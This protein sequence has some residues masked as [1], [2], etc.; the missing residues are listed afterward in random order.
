MSSPLEPDD[1]PP[2]QCYDSKG[3]LGKLENRVS[4]GAGTCVVQGGHEHVRGW[5]TNKQLC[6][7]RDDHPIVPRSCSVPNNGWIC[8]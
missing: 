1:N 5:C 3:T 6:F 7:L 2:T 4:A 8:Q